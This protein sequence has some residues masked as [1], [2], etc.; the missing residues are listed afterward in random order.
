MNIVAIGGG[1]IRE[2]ETLSIDRFIRD[3]SG[4]SVPNLLF[5]PTASHDNDGYC[6]VVL[7]VYGSELGC[8]VSDLKLMSQKP[9]SNEIEEKILGADIIYVG[10]GNTKSMLEVWQSHSVDKL[11][12]QAAVNGTILSGLSAGAVC[13]YDYGHSDYESFTSVSEWEYKLL[14]GLQFTPGVFCPHLDAENRLTDFQ[15]MLAR[16]SLSGIGCDNNAAVWHESGSSPM[17]IASE[18]NA[19]VKLVDTKS[20]GTSITTF[21]HGDKLL[22]G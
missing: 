15:E 6:D 20:T 9:S 3:L 12:R 19:T 10:G 2:R 21:S 8:T 4:K 1:L 14:P 5:L 22:Y 7:E 18:K 11:L 13:W 16:N 17:V